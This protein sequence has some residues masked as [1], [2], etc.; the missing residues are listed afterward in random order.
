MLPLMFILYVET[1][2][3]IF[4]RITKRPIGKIDLP[5]SSNVEMTPGQIQSF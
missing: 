4:N 1:R 2:F 5:I 3:D